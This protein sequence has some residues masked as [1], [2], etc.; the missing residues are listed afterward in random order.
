VKTLLRRLKNWYRTHREILHTIAA[1][2][3]VMGIRAAAAH[4]GTDT[5]FDDLNTLM[6][7]WSKG[8]LGKALALIALLL[9]IGIAAARQSFAALFAGVGVAAGAAIGPGVIDQV[10]TAVF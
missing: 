5:T 6:S 7:D 9:G 2:A 4:A 1:L 8:S 3:I 10:V